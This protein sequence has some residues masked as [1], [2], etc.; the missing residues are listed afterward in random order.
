DEQEKEKAK[1]IARLEL[2]RILKRKNQSGGSEKVDKVIRKAV[3][4][5]ADK[6]LEGTAP[7][8]E[9]WQEHLIA[10]WLGAHRE[11]RG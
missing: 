4:A 7:F 11:E 6:K 2:E 8:A 1:E 5:H 3:L 10:R 9:V